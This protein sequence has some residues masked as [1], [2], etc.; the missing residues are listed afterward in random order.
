MRTQLL[1]HDGKR[2]HIHH[3][4]H[5]PGATAELAASEQMLMNIDTRQARSAPFADSVAERI[6]QLAEIH[7]QLPAPVHVGRVIALPV[8]HQG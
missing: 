5:Y 6:R 8:R 4:L 3:S 2:L 7:T 1:G